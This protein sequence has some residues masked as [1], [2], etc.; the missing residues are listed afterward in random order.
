[1][2]RHASTDVLSLHGDRLARSITCYAAVIPALAQWADLLMSNLVADRALIVAGNGGSA[3]HADHFVAELIG[4]FESPRRAL[5]AS[6]LFGPSPTLTALSNDFGYATAARRLVH[7]SCRSGDV[8]LCISTSGN[9]ANLLEAVE[10]ARELDVESWSL[11]GAT[12]SKLG[13]ASDSVIVLSGDSRATTQELHLVALH[14]LC[15]AIDARLRD[16]DLA[17]R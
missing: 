16:M 13:E 4:H 11:V 5:R 9:S 7:A 1:M 8:L 14:G 10:A 12:D 3:A 2:P 6:A 15:A 17:A